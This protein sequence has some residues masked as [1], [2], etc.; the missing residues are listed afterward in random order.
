MP[1]P[2]DFLDAH[3]RHWCD[4]ELLFNDSRWAN[5]DQMYGFSAECG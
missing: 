4:A 2:A 5:A 1:H 3:R